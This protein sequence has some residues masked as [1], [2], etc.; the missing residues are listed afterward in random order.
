MTKVGIRVKLIAVPESGERKRNLTTPGLV[1]KNRKVK[2]GRSRQRS[3]SPL[4]IRSNV[5][6]QL[7]ALG[8]DVVANHDTLALLGRIKAHF[9]FP[10]TPAAA[11][12]KTASKGNFSLRKAIRSI[13]IAV[14]QTGTRSFSWYGQPTS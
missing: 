11:C 4:R 1:K 8:K 7:E 13:A 2:R 10:N 12:K 3:Q 6:V 5:L 14:L 9:C